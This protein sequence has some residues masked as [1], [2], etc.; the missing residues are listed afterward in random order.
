MQYPGP[1]I[2]LYAPETR[3]FP[4]RMGIINIVRFLAILIF[5]PA[6]IWGQTCT[7]VPLLRPADSQAGSLGDANCQ[8]SDGSLFATYVLVLPTYGRLQLS[9]SS[10]DF[11]AALILR[12]SNGH[13]I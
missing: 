11:P 4:P 1:F 7:P 13:R 2:A 3:T 12:D 5:L 10:D 6:L 9:V 8:L